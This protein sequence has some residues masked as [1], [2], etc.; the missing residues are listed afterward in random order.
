MSAGLRASMIAPPVKWKTQ[1]ISNHQ[2]KENEIKK[3]LFWK[4]GWFGWNKKDLLIKLN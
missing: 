4:W 1:F 2:M 3:K